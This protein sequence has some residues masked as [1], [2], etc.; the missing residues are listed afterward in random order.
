MDALFLYHRGGLRLFRWIRRAAT[1]SV[2]SFWRVARRLYRRGGA[3][4]VMEYDIL[5][6]LIGLL[7]VVVGV[8]TFSVGTGD[9]DLGVVGVRL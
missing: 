1:P 6:P 7:S 9:R 4:D 5:T 8:D 2:V 3:D